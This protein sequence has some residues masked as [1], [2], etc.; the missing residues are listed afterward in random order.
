[1]DALFGVLG[2][3]FHKLIKTGPGGARVVVASPDV[4]IQFTSVRAL[5]NSIDLTIAILRT[6]IDSEETKP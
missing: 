1:M 4:N 2:L 3:S 5:G 6:Q